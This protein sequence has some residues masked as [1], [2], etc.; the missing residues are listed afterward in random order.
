[1]ERSEM[2]GLGSRITPRCARLHPGYMLLAG[3]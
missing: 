3:K 2:R 1:M